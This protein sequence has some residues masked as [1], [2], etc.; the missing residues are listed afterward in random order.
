MDNLIRQAPPQRR[1]AVVDD[2]LGVRQ[3][4]E[5]L[6][7]SAGFLVSTFASPGF[8]GPGRSAV[9]ELILNVPGR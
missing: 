9:V 1:M 8:S 7:R 5:R 4:L 6:L 2:D 3:A